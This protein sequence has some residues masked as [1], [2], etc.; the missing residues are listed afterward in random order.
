MKKLDHGQERLANAHEKARPP[1]RF[2]ARMKEA[3]LVGVALVGLGGCASG[4]AGAQARPGNNVSQN[5]SATAG[6]SGSR[7]TTPSD[8][9]SISTTSAISPT[10]TTIEIG[11]R[12][13]NIV[14]LDQRLADLNTKT[15][16]YREPEE[17]PVE[18]GGTGPLATTN[19]RYA[20]S[21]LV[22]GEARFLVTL[23][24]REN[25]RSLNI[26]FPRERDSE[27]SAPGAGVR[28]VNLN[29]FAA[30]VRALT[31]QEMARVNFIVEA[32]TFNNNGVT[33]NY[34]NAYIFP[35]N[36]RGEVITRRGNGAFIIYSG[37]YYASS[38]GGSASLLIE[39]NGRDS[40]YAS[41]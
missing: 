11:G 32:G 35:L 28:T 8:Y 14:R 20:N 15:A 37:S 30:Y 19:G 12:T 18:M 2:W 17:L 39:P 23:L 6:A 3:A 5:S 38:A 24:P 31:G 7:S 10:A 34:T 25:R 29:E 21:V 40:L 27:P 9:S 16:R 4:L 26:I 33:T 1:S 36:S 13:L 41:R 22:P